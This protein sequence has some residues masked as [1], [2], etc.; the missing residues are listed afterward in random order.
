MERRLFHSYLGAWNLQRIARL[1]ECWCQP[2]PTYRHQLFR[3]NRP[4]RHLLSPFG[5]AARGPSRSCLGILPHRLHGRQLALVGLRSPHGE[6]LTVGVVVLPVALASAFTTLFLGVVLLGSAHGHPPQGVA[7]LLN[8]TPSRRLPPRTSFGSCE[9]GTLR[10][11]PR[12]VN[13]LDHLPKRLEVHALR[14]VGT[15]G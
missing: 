14:V 4:P 10:P 8:T 1:Y 5:I 7:G 15:E 6:G 3:M 2:S 11:Y 9:H 12:V 13:V